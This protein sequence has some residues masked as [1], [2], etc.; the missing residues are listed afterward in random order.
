MQFLNRRLRSYYL[1]SDGTL[2]GRK[3]SKTNIGRLPFK[4]LGE[5]LRLPA[6]LKS[7]AAECRHLLP[8]M[9][10]LC[11]EYKAFLGHGEN[12]LSMAVLD[13]NAIYDVMAAEPRHMSA[14]GLKILE[15]R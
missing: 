8:L 15:Q 2:G 5:E 9:V 1:A 11:Q 7:K 3:G 14:R 13:M 10:L 12:Y 6:R 4:M